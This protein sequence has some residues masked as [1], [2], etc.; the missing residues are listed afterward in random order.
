MQ[1]TFSKYLLIAGIALTISCSRSKE[2]I[3][4][5]VIEQ[6]KMV[7]VLS[8]VH[9]TEAT[10]QLRNLNYSDSTR[11]IAYGYYKEVFQK[12]HI[13]PEQFKES[14]MWY[15]SHPEVMNDMYK[16]IITRL[17]EEQAKEGN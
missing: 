17:S 10:I 12:H 6:K 16:E 8:D 15:K 3:P 14:F 7:E 1:N 9:Y 13:T 11:K 2:E 5:S 4:S